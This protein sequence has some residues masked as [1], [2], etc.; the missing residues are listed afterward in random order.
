METWVWLAAYLIGFAL[1]QLYLY[2]Y[3]MNQSTTGSSERATPVADRRGSAL[4]VPEDV[5]E[6]DLVTCEH[7]G[8][9]NESH[10]MFSFCR[11]C[12]NRLK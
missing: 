11:E 2:R 6:G 9:Y 8:S 7:C 5:S 3:F 10:Q 1:L 12:G 4:E